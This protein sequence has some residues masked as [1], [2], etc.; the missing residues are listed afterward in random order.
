MILQ[1]QC[2]EDTRRKMK[3]RWTQLLNCQIHKEKTRVHVQWIELV[4]D[5]FLLQR[6]V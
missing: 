4:T 2:V 5:M 3:M 6:I 1:F